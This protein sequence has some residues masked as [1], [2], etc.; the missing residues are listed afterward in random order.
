M[1]DTITFIAKTK[2]PN[3][4]ITVKLDKKII[5]EI[6]P[7]T[8]GWQYYPKGM[9]KGGEVFENLSLCQKSLTEE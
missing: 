4:I 5:G 1:F 7:V 9:K 8:G 2:E 6:R 3:S